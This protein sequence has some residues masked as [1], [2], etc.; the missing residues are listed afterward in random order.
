M[1]HDTPRV[2]SR[3][4]LLYLI[5]SEFNAGLEIKEVLFNVLT[6]TVA[7]VGASEAS[8][9]LID[10]QGRLEDSI[11]IRGF[12]RQNYS[13]EILQYLFKNGVVGWVHSNQRGVIISNTRSDPIWYK[14]VATPEI[15]RAVSVVAVPVQ[16]SSQN[17]MGIITITTEQE[18]HFDDDDLSMLTIIADQTAFALT[19]ARLF[20]TE[21][22]RR[23]VADTLASIAHTV[24]ATLDLNEVLD[25]ILEQLSLVVEYDSSSILLYE[26]NNIRPGGTSGTRIPRHG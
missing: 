12:K 10:E 2:S 23:K 22:H 16:K 13:Q 17:P 4:D 26:P 11:V 6:A 7:S 15:S 18:N 9:F 3:L 19:N 8:L 24:N 25:L 20:D 14:E 1:L 5:T 21:Q